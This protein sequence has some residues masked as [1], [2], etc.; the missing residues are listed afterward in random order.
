[1]NAAE[2]VKKAQAKA[3]RDALALTMLMQLRAA[4]LELGLE[5]EHAFHPARKWRFDFA[6]PRER[7]ALEVDGGVFTGG[8]HTRGAG[9]EADAEKLNEAALLGWSV[10]R[11]TTNH[12]GSGMALHWVERLIGA[13]RA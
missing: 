10:L 13:K 7:V 9:F 1:M 4:G 6:W 5:R 11:V 12:V 8:R 2:V 3:K